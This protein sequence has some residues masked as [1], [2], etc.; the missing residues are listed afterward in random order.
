M[1]RFVLV[2]A[3]L[4]A[5]AACTDGQNRSPTS[6]ASVA[7]PSPGIRD[8][9]ARLKTLGYYDG[10][11]DGFWGPET[12]VA[13][14]RY[15]RQ[16]NLPVTK[17]LDQPTTA[18]LLASPPPPSDTV[19]E[20]QERL[21]ALGRYSGTV[22]GIAGPDTR[23]A[24]EGFQRD[25]RLAVTGDLTPQTMSALRAEPAR[26]AQR[27]S[28]V[29]QATDPTS[30]RTV[31]N[32]LRQLGF[33]DGA[34]DGVWGRATQVSLERFQRA[35]GL[36]VSGQLNTATVNAMGLDPAAF[37]SA[38]NGNASP[39]EPAVVRNIQRRLKQEGFYAGPI[40]GNWGR[41]SQTAVRR[42]QTS[43]GLDA[44]GELTPATLSALGLDPNNL[45]ESVPARGGP[46]SR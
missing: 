22:D 4:L 35:R 18:A 20:A 38:S 25:R 17:Q 40:D 33:Y 45:A 43:R 28:T 8:A 31:Q 14:E 6:S 1:K 36:Q 26:S 42:F 19:R 21:R 16:N 3:I 44:N 27:A 9:Q 5:A 34:S 29:I 32:R 46:A 23:T 39:L 13:V 15:Q 11:V 12:Q 7:Q 30:V 2:G 37:P 41:G 24:V 10:A